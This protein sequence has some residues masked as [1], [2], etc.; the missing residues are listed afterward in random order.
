[1]Y[2]I[3]IMRYLIQINNAVVIQSYG[4]ST[5]TP[6]EESKLG[7]NKD[8]ISNPIASELTKIAKKHIIK[9]NKDQTVSRTITHGDN[10]DSGNSTTDKTKIGEF[11]NVYNEIKPDNNATSRDMF[12]TCLVFMCF[13]YIYFFFYLLPL[14]SGISLHD[15]DGGFVYCVLIVV[16]A[17]LCDGGGLFIGNLF[18]KNNFGAPITPS[19]TKEGLYGSIIFG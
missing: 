14:T 11:V 12:I 1:M 16:I 4:D 3:W 17:Y 8:K 7:N 13:D 5:A 9:A 19:K 6:N 2:T 15:L 10:T 18:G